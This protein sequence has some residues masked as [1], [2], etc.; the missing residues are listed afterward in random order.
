MNQTLAR[1][2]GLAPIALPPARA[3]G[4]PRYATLS[5]STLQTA[6]GRLKP[7]NVSGPI[8]LTSATSATAAATRQPGSAVLAASAEA[9][10]GVDDCADRAADR[11]VLEA[12]LLQRRKASARADAKPI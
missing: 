6:S 12:D 7:L 1:L 5:A 11:S 8:S 9:R 2:H 10:G 4:D 3:P